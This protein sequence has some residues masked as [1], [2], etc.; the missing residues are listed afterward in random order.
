MWFWLVEKWDNPVVVLGL[1]A[2]VKGLL[3]VEVEELLKGLVV[4]PLFAVFWLLTPNEIL[5]AVLELKG[6]LVS[7][8][9]LVVFVNVWLV[10]KGKVEVEGVLEESELALTN[11]LFTKV[12]VGFD[13]DVFEEKYG[14]IEDVVEFELVLEERKGLITLLLLVVVDDWFEKMF[15]LWLVNGLFNI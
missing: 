9:V 1:E 15:V 12:L 5:A 11:G 8:L 2:N 10:E 4:N 6:L 3:T 13:V 14:L 7:P